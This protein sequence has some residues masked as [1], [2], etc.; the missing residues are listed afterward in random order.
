MNWSCR[1]GNSVREPGQR[2]WIR[3]PLRL[4]TGHTAKPLHYILISVPNSIPPVSYNLTVVYAIVIKFSRSPDSEHLAGDLLRAEQARPG[5]EF[6]EMISKYIR[7]G[8]IVPMEVTIKVSPMFH[9]I[10]GIQE[11]RLISDLAGF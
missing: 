11:L 2:L 6:G 5:S 9:S 7:E 8:N 10:Y 4:V 1:K 3:T